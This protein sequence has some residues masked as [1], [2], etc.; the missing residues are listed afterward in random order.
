MELM[1]LYLSPGH[2]YVGHH[3]L[4]P[5]N[6]PMLE[7]PELECVAGRGL[8]GDRYFDHRP[9][10]KGQ[11]TF[12]AYET[13]EHLCRQLET[14]DRDPSVFRRNVVVRGIDLDSLVGCHFEVQGVQFEGVESCKP[15]YWMDQSF[16]PGAEAALSG[17]GGLRARILSNGRLRQGPAALGIGDRES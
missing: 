5:G 9:D 17:R 10:Y 15:C 16:A 7:V 14:A 12:F 2:N 13:F 3:G 11:I 8:R 6:H 1:H 4:P